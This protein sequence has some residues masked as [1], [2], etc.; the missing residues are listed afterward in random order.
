MVGIGPTTVIAPTG[1]I[2]M[3]V[4]IIHIS[5]TSIGT[6]T[7]AQIPVIRTDEAGAAD[8]VHFSLISTA[9]SNSPEKFNTD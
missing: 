9:P 1:G 6:G 5:V 7:D 4:D 8:S 3:E 2:T